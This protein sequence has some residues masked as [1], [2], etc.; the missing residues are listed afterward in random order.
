MARQD[1]SVENVEGWEELHKDGIERDISDALA[2]FLLDIGIGQVNEKN[3][4]EI[5][6]RIREVESACGMK[7]R[8][9]GDDGSYPFVPI[10]ADSI[11][12]RFGMWAN[13]TPKTKTFFNGQIA[14]E[15]AAKV[16]F[17]ADQARHKASQE[18]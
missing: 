7:L 8:Q 12:R 15:K 17:E 10:H 11:R 13:V 2:W 1:W 4:L 9:P 3:F 6:R 16:R 5:L 18:V 14:K